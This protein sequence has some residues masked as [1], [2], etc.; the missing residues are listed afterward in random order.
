MPP[1]APS[2]YLYNRPVR[3]LDLPGNKILPF[4][5]RAAAQG[6]VHT[7]LQPRLAMTAAMAFFSIAL[8]LNLTG[9]HLS[10]L[11]AEDLKPSAIRKS[12]YE[13]NAHVVRYCDNLR[14]V[15][16]LEARAHDLRSTEEI[17]APA[18]DK[19]ADP[20]SRPD[21]KPEEQ[22][23][24]PKPGP[25][26]SRREP[27]FRDDLYRAALVP[28]RITDPIAL[29]LVNLSPVTAGTSKVQIIPKGDLA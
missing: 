21:E 25:G 20:K 14:V 28:S 23:T 29:T 1:V 16:E 2:P 7:M 9:V 11:T 24:R 8:T 5:I 13:A 22:K 6:F 19:Q 26:T 4:R 12:F 3:P 18:P 10:A 17:P 15:Y 27:L